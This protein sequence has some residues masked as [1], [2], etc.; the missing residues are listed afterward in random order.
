V[1]DFAILPNSA[2]PWF[3]TMNA[4]FASE[5]NATMH[6]TTAW[7][8]W[9]VNVNTRFDASTF[10][11]SN[12]TFASLSGLNL[13]IGD[14]CATN[15]TGAAVA[16]P[17]MSLAFSS[18]RL[19][20]TVPSVS[21]S[22]YIEDANRAAGICV[23]KSGYAPMPG[24]KA[25]VVGKIGTLTSGE[26]CIYADTITDAPDTAVAP[27]AMTNK[28]LV[29][30]QA[31]LQPG[32][33]GGYGLNNIGLLSRTTGFVDNSYGNSF[34]IY[35]GSG[36]KVRVI[37]TDSSLLPV[38][39]SYVVV[40]GVCSIEKDTDGKVQRVLYVTDVTPVTP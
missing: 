8:F 12:E 13:I 33:D 4:W 11:V 39:G 14:L 31:G 5:G 10:G 37:L 17:S 9:P 40:T 27:L 6:S 20:G 38:A 19:E 16:T 3:F 18:M 36:V 1:F 7:Q 28:S 35:D 24:K 15:G 29:G 30:G 23:V 25:N 34:N 32:V 21:S 2:A 22:F 26:K